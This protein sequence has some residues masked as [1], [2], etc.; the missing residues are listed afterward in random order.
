MEQ[1]TLKDGQ[2]IDQ[3]GFGTYKLNGTKGVHAM[4]DALNMGYRL[5]DTAYNYENE[6]AVGKAIQN[7]HVNRDE[8]WV[9]SK[10]PGRY[11]SEANVYETIQESLYR[12]GLDYLDFYLIHWPNPKQGKYVEAWKA[13]IAAQKSGLVRHIGVCNFLPEHIEKLEKET[14]VLPAIN[15]IELHPFFNQKEMIA[16]HE[17]KGILTQAWSP[18]GRDNGVMDEP[19]LKQ[20]S[21]KYDKTVAQVILR[22]HVQNGV[23]P[24]P[25][26]T[27]SKRQLENFDIF[28]F[29]ITDEDLQAINQLTRADGRRKNQDPAVYEEF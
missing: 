14:G 28:D 22:W 20:L 9:T 10:L 23:M 1:F 2:F 6:G 17:E 21:A 7:S 26:A 19:V 12:L 11:Q 25:K 16:Y 3:L 4:T 27:S 29:H 24:I 13:M 18:L 15:Q 8:I 5:L